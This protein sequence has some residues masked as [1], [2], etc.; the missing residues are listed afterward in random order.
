M[1]NT[2]ELGLNDKYLLSR[3]TEWIRMGRPALANYFGVPIWQIRDVVDQLDY[4]PAM[5]EEPPLGGL[6]SSW[7]ARFE[8]LRDLKQGFGDDRTVIHLRDPQWMSELMVEYTCT[9]AEIAWI[10]EIPE[11]LVRMWAEIHEIPHF[12]PPQVPEITD[13]RSI[14][15]QNEGLSPTPGVQ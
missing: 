12:Q 13:Y 2:D 6:E 1:D 11:Y 9:V 15:G 3:F 8:V 10:F 14:E 5:D 7:S 4:E